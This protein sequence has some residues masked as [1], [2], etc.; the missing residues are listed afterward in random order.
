[1]IEKYLYPK[2]PV[3]C[4]ISG[5]SSSGKSTLLFKILLNIINDFDKILIFSPTIHQ[6]IYQ[7][8]IKCFENFLPSN[9]IQNILKE[10]ISLEK[11]DEVIEEII[12]DED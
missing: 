3:R 8:L 10:G 5:K 1:M 9:I 11:L 4:I 7:K 12:K 2:Y 6:P